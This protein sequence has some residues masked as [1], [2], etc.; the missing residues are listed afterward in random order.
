MD[1][2]FNE[3]QN[4]AIKHFRGPCLCIAGPGSG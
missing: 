1:Y 2:K 3:Q 4:Q